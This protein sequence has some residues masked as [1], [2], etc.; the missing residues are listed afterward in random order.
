MLK[1]AIDF[2]KI[3]WGWGSNLYPEIDKISIENEVENIIVA[4]NSLDGFQSNLEAKS[5]T[6]K[7]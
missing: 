5:P 4:G 3:S 7:V 6:K 2:L 1:K